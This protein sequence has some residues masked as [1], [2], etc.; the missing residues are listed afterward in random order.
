MGVTSYYA[1][2]YGD[3]RRMDI[4]E[5][6][7]SMQ[8]N[9]AV[10]A[11]PDKDKLVFLE[12]TSQTKAFGFE[13]DFTDD[14]FALLVKPEGG[15]IVKTKK[16]VDKDNSQIT[17][18]KFIVNED[19]SV[20][21][22]AT[23]E[24]KG[25]QYENISSIDKLSND[26]VKNLFKK[27][28][29]NLNELLINEFKTNNDKEKILFTETVQLIAPY[30]LQKIGAEKMLTINVLNQSNS[31]PQR[32]R[33]RKNGFEIVKGYYD[34][35]NIEI[36]IPSIYKVSS[37]PEAVNLDTKF[38]T[39]HAEVLILDVNKIQYKRSLLIKKGD[40]NVSD[41]E[42]FRKFKEQI[43]KNDNSKILLQTN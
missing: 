24:Y 41:Y 43:A 22:D 33:N 26:K 7:V 21:I 2:I 17:K 13:G 37:K 39:Y 35:D 42:D 15:Q 5:D 12:C 34:E 38:G 14:R 23:I 20:K 6:F 27:R 32:Y 36:E 19:G 30:F 8:G 10:L 11:I 29:S 18:G 3:Q 16:Y 28:W 1:I 4:L 25:I 40:Y 9:H 31:V